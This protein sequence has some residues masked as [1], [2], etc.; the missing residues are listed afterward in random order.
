MFNCLQ[1][2]DNSYCIEVKDYRNVDNLYELLHYRVKIIFDSVSI[3]FYVFFG[4]FYKCV[5]II[6]K[7]VVLYFEIF[8]KNLL[9][10]LETHRF[11]L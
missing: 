8:E 4:L 1:D 2:L 6:E 10:C 7:F 11:I 9:S 5:S 3:Y